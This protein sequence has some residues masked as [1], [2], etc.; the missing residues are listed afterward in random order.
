[1]YVAKGRARGVFAVYEPAMHAAARENLELHNLLRAAIEHD[2]VYLEYQPVHRLS[3][4]A[5]VGR[6]GAR[7][8]G[9]AGP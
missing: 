5:V 1:M 8:L 3:T 4:G 2:D 6:R 9:P 7:A